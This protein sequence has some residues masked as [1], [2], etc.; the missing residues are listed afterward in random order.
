MRAWIVEVKKAPA[1]LL[2]LAA[3]ALVATGVLLAGG[4]ALRLGAT[5]AAPAQGRTMSE[6][7][8][9]ALADW[10]RIVLALAIPMFLA[11]AML[12]IFITPRI[13]VLLFGM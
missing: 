6:A 9:E 1:G 5:L 10:C 8:I 13:A 7:L 4:A 2:V 12:E 11:A 3:G